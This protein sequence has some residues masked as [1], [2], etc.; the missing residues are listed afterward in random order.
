MKKLTKEDYELC[1]KIAEKAINLGIYPA[2]CKAIALMDITN[3]AKHYNMRL[4]EWLM[5]DDF[6]FVHDIVGIANTIDRKAFPA[7]FSND[8]YFLPR[9]AGESEE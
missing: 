5:S 4:K 6:N 8:K 2:D 9:F 1:G 3:A 7:N